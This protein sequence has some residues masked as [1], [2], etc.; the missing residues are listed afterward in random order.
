MIL[1]AESSTPSIGKDR[2]LASLP[3]RGEIL[4][5]PNPPLPSAR[6]PGAQGPEPGR[7]IRIYWTDPRCYRSIGSTGNER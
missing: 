4:R 1:R 5:D 2:N 6:C 3:A 7:P